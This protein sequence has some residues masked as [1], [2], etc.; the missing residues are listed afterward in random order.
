MTAAKFQNRKLTLLPPIPQTLFFPKF[1][2]APKSVSIYRLPVPLAM[3]TLQSFAA[4]S[5]TAA[6]RGLDRPYR[7]E[8]TLA[9]ERRQDP[10]RGNCA[11]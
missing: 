2:S 4:C 11:D 10:D 5:Q 8:A 6:A 7:R 3:V 1:R 9:V